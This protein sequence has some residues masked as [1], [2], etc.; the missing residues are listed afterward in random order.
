M[1]WGYKHK[2]TVEKRLDGAANRGNCDFLQIKNLDRN[3][4]KAKLSI[5]RE[6]R[7]RAI[8]IQ[9][10]GLNVCV[11]SLRHTNHVLTVALHDSNLKEEASTCVQKFLR[12]AVPILMVEDFEPYRTQIVSLPGRNANLRVICE[13]G[14]GLQAVQRAHELRPDLILMD[15]GL[16]GLN[17]ID[18]AG[19]I[20]Q[21]TPGSKILFLT[22]ESSADLVR[23]VLNMGAH[24]Y[25]L[26]SQA[27]GELLGAIEAVL[28]GKRFVNGG[29][30]DGASA[31]GDGKAPT[32]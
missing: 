5:G 13:V 32:Y 4:R 29:L 7:S 1:R 22:Q 6:S 8:G 31:V 3:I 23:E 25:V 2:T 11:E 26:K 27:E 18:A 15:I 14:D 16:P 30:A 20:F 10:P 24:G 28:E 9:L 19:K 21:L 17:G 12:Q